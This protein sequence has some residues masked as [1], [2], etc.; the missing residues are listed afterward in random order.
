MTKQESRRKWRDGGLEDHGISQSVLRDLEAAEKLN[1]DLRDARATIDLDA[2]IRSAWVDLD[3]VRVDLD[4]VRA[5]LDVGIERTRLADNRSTDVSIRA[6]DALIPKRTDVEVAADITIKVFDLHEGIAI[7]PAADLSSTMVDVQ[8][9]VSNSAVS[10]FSELRRREGSLLS[11]YLSS[12]IGALGNKA[13]Y[14]LTKPVAETM[15]E[16]IDAQNL[17]NDCLMRQMSHTMRVF[18][19]SITETTLHK[20][21]PIFDGLGTHFLHDMVE[22]IERVDW[23]TIERAARVQEA[24]RPRTKIGFE[25]LKAYNAF[26][27]SRHSVVDRFLKRYLNLEPNAYTREAL[28]Q[29]LRSA[30]ERTIP[31]PATWIVLPDEQAANYLYVAVFN[32]ARRIRRDRE[33]GDRLWWGNSAPQETP[34]LAPEPRSRLNGKAEDPLE[35]VA[36]RMDDRAQVLDLLSLNGT[37]QDQKIVE[38]IS[39]GEFA[40]VDIAESVGRTRL[41]AFQRKAQRWRENK[42]DLPRD[43]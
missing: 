10:F 20:M 25:A 29:E 16:W 7:P 13:V 15:K 30:F 35:I 9:G 31:E 28:W 19:T 21:R 33:M 37:P 12:A 43:G 40:L 38:L 1:D 3:S 32:A 27:L 22:T 11:K 17:L 36:R 8:R 5:D 4:S 41:Q 42:L 39:S 18:E 26:Y 23:Q 2:D 34:L 14:E 6:A 24:R